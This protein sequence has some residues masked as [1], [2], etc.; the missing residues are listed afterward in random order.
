MRIPM[1]RLFSTYKIESTSS[2]LDGKNLADYMV[3]LW[4]QQNANNT[5]TPYMPIK[6]ELLLQ[7]P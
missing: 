6:C 4:F 3:G 2:S 5:L 1:E 7:Y